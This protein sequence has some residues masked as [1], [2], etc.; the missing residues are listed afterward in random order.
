MPK[1]KDITGQRF[2]KLVVLKETNERAS[3]GSILWECKCDCGNIILTTGS[4]LR[5][6]K[7]VSCGKCPR[8]ENLIGQKFNLLTVI[9]DTH[10]KINEKEVWECQCECGNIVK[11]HSANL[12]NGSVKSCGCLGS[13]DYDLTNQRFGKLVVKYK[14]ET[15]N[16]NISRKW[17]CQCD[18]GN[19]II[20]TTNRLRSGQV[21]SCGCLKHSVGELKIAQFL[22]ENNIPFETQKTF[23]TAKYSKT[24]RSMRFDF[25]LPMQNILIEYD[26]LQHFQPVEY[27]GGNEKFQIQQNNDKEKEEW[28]KANNIYLK[29]IKYTKDENIIFNKLQTILNRCN[30]VK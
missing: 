29:R 11:V 27:F 2:N 14:I 7:R 25:Y 26:G 16:R 24:N 1:K 12:K 28:C 20:V 8:Y 17:L 6:G 18:C 30:E 19:E 13:K 10:T 5:S 3:N 4:E 22:L 15:E 21:N 9:A 23:D